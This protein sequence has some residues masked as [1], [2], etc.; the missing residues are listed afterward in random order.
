VTGAP[1]VVRRAVGGFGT[2]IV[3]GAALG[4]AAW[5]SDQLQ[6]PL[7]LVIPA[8]LIAA[9]LGVA[10]ALGASARTIPTGALRGLVGLL[11]AVVAYYLLIAALGQGFRAIGASHA[12]TI[13]GAV[14]LLAGPVMG[15]AGAV[16]RYGQGWPRALG[17]ALIAAAF[18]GEGVVFGA[19]RWMHPDQLA[20]DP[21]AFLL[22]AEVVIGVALPFVLLR[23]GERLRGY[24]ATA[25]LATAAAV[26][27]GP[28][29]TILRSLAD[30]F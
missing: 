13:W 5:V 10:F 2:S 26:A 21:G 12:A 19:S 18:I 3:A 6:W 27:I 8:N 30:R 7:S 16:W 17:V 24:A 28:V 1:S 23:R 4:V 29:T 11:S 15:G 14:A 22:G 20:A 25:A 9:W